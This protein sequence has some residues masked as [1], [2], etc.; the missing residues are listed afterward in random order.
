MEIGVE[1]RE[2]KIVAT[3]NYGCDGNNGTVYENRTMDRDNFLEFA[4]QFQNSRSTFVEFVA[5]IEY[6]GYQLRGIEMFGVE[7]REET[8]KEAIERFA[9]ANREENESAQWREDKDREKYL[10]LKERFES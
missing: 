9:K 2:I 8:E 4:K 7:V 5:D 1:K 6:D 10:E 3:H